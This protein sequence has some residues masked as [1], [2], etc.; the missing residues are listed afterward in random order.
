M[1]KN[2]K[3]KIINLDGIW[4][5]QID[6][7]YEGT[8]RG[9]ANDDYD[10]SCWR[11][12][13]TP[14]TFEKCFPEAKAYEGTCW[15]KRNVFV[16]KNV[17]GK[18]AVL[19]F[20]AVN[21]NTDIWINGKHAGSNSYG[22][23][24]FEISVMELLKY[25]DENVITVR[26]SNKVNYGQLPS[27]FFWRNFGGI[28][29]SSSLIFT[30]QTYIVSLK[31]DAV[32]FSNGEGNLKI[33][34]NTDSIICSSEELRAEI[35]VWEYA[36]KKTMGMFT[37]DFKTTQSGNLTLVSLEENIKNINL[38]SPGNPFLY[39]A[40]VKLYKQDLLLDVLKTRLG[41]RTIEV[42]GENIL[43]NGEPIFLKGFNR[44]ED[45]PNTGQ[46]IDA[47]N[48]RKDYEMIK[49]TGANFVR[50]CHYPHDV[51]ELDLCDELGL[52]VMDEIPLCGFLIDWSKTTLGRNLDYARQTLQQT[53]ISAKEQLEILINRDYNHPSVVIWSVGNENNELEEDV[54]KMLGNLIKY[55]KKLDNSRPAVHVCCYWSPDKADE[56]FK[57][58]DIIC[59]NNYAMLG[60]RGSNNLDFGLP[61][62]Q[63]V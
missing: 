52:M 5:A 23:L 25:G 6:F 57:Y 36:S 4:K 34:I 13:D 26:V 49:S 60:E 11:I 35:S 9:Y 33:Q 43:L 31:V 39:L 22:F 38:W 37:L 42:I 1:L 61:E 8:Q 63:K 30:S 48:T 18:R 44:H 12:I 3:R 51:S 15:F 58:D 62:L 24:P 56:L 46:A 19:H 54:P 27:N 17:S 28:I 53:F 14:C 20:D 32:P 50:M 59:I 40:E 2:D 47:Q 21:Y 55:V 29:R 45:S 10:D 41:F 16:P 7:N